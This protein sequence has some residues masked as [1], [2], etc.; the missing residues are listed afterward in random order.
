MPREIQITQFE[1]Y[2]VVRR[3][4]D[5]IIIGAPHGGER[6]LLNYLNMRGVNRAALLFTQP[7]QPRDAERLAQILP[8]I[9]TVYLPAHAEGTTLSLMN[10]T[11]ENLPFQP[12]IIFLQDGDIR[13]AR[14][15]FIQV[16]A[17]PLGKF[18]FVV[19]GML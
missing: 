8:R 19:Q 6:D 5:T 12:E 10:N 14:G 18:E 1:N 15:V 2:T 13:A 17:I 11:L 9:H 7:P 4:A 3:H 16:R